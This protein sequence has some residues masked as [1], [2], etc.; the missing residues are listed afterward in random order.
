MCKQSVHRFSHWSPGLQTAYEDSDS[1]RNYYLPRVG[2]SARF[3][4]AQRKVEKTFEL[5]IASQKQLNL[6]QLL[7]CSKETK[8]I[9]LKSDGLNCIK[10]YINTTDSTSS[11][12][13]KPNNLLGESKSESIREQWL[14]PRKTARPQGQLKNEQSQQSQ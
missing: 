2:K 10:L 11:R 13:S 1:Q 4:R 5:V 3:H 8:T 14:N 9:Q 6:A 7:F 12:D